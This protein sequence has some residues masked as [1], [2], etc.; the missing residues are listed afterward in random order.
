LPAPSA[1][2]LE[3]AAEKLVSNVQSIPQALKLGHMLSELAARVEL[4]PFPRPLES[5]LFR[6][7]GKPCP[8]KARR[9]AKASRVTVLTGL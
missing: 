7:F 5:D 8:F 3:Q 6:S 9:A 1:A 4:V 2:R